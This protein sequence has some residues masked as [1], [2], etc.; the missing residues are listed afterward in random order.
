[1]LQ[2]VDGVGDAP[3]NAMQILKNWVLN[4]QAGDDPTPEAWGEIHE[5]VD[6]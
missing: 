5:E 4:L 2:L 1:V 6:I 3:Y